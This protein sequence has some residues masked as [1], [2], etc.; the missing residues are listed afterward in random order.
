[1]SAEFG[2]NR[3]CKKLPQINLGI[4]TDYKN[5]LPILYRYVSGAIRDVNTLEKILTISDEYNLDIDMLIIWTKGSVQQ[6]NIT[7]NPVI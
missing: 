3:D 6:S 5:K 1:M 4:F 2:Y 7:Y